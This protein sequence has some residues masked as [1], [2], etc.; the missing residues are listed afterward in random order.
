MKMNT[1]PAGRL[2][3]KILGNHEVG[4]KKGK[5][6]DSIS[7]FLGQDTSINGTIEFQGAIRLDGKVD[8][9]ICSNG[10]TVIIGEKAVINADIAVDV[11]I[12]MGEVNGSIEAKNRIEI[13][14]PGR[15]V[16]NIQ[17]P[18]VSIE[19]GVMFNGN[20]IMKTRAVLPEKIT[21]RPKKLS[22]MK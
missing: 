2:L 7:T 21:D 18:T 15:V 17:A 19:A 1:A 6:R 9:K 20:F 8:G 11:A 13:Y 4:I 12:I 10:G 14:P 22:V 3:R 5:K 16:G